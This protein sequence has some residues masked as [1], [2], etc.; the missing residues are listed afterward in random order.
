M[1]DDSSAQ[2]ATI[3]AYIH[4]FRYAAP[5]APEKRQDLCDSARKAFWWLDEENENETTHNTSAENSIV[6]T[7]STPYDSL[8]AES[9]PRSALQMHTSQVQSQNNPQ[10]LSHVVLSVAVI[11]EAVT[12]SKKH[13][14][15]SIG[16]DDLVSDTKLSEE[17]SLSI[18]PVSKA[19][20][21]TTDMMTI[22][23]LCQSIQSQ[24]EQSFQSLMVDETDWEIDVQQILRDCD[25][26]IEDY[27]DETRQLT[28]DTSS[29]HI[30]KKT[31]HSEDNS[32]TKILTR[33]PQ[34]NHVATDSVSPILSYAWSH[35]KTVAAGSGEDDNDDSDTNEEDEDGDNEIINSEEARRI[36]ARL[37]EEYED[38]DDDEEADV[39]INEENNHPSIVIR[40]PAI[41][42]SALESESEIRHAS[43]HHEPIPPLHAAD[44][45]VQ[46]SIAKEQSSPGPTP[47]TPGMSLNFHLSSSSEGLLL[48]IR[49]ARAMRDLEDDVISDV[50][51]ENT[52]HVLD[53]SILQ[54]EESLPVVDFAFVKDYLED[55]VVLQLWQRLQHL[56]KLQQQK[57]GR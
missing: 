11:S 33:S 7:S 26:L 4:R 19:N 57:Q 52:L 43:P 45:P 36:L 12:V 24:L 17:V 55:D 16:I 20:H 32:E 8:E 21:L 44:S 13:T 6:S 14:V 51:D 50:A 5:T 38:D 27:R 22:P 54:P 29:N 3:S 28:T 25:Q 10:L 35:N 41:S 23:S 15:N 31:N 56:R 40:S 42:C 18:G 53:A 2:G 1:I 47:G 37:R 9:M 39:N 34:K 46:L 30:K 49:K 48:P